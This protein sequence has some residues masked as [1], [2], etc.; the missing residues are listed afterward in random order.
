MNRST[1]IVVVI[2]AAALVAVSAVA[3]HAVL[4]RPDTTDQHH[5]AAQGDGE[6]TT[7]KIVGFGNSAIIGFRVRN[8][9]LLAV[10]E[11]GA[12]RAYPIDSAGHQYRV[13]R[14]SDWTI[15]NGR[16]ARLLFGDSVSDAR[17]AATS[18]LYFTTQHGVRLVAE[19][20]LSAALSKDGLIAYT[21]PEYTVVVVDERLRRLA[22]FEDASQPQW[23]SNGDLLMVHAVEG[24]A[25]DWSSNNELVL[26][27]RDGWRSELLADSSY[28]AQS[29]IGIPGTEAVLFVGRKTGL[30]SFWRLE[31]GSR[32]VT[33]LT[34]VEGTAGE[35][36]V[37]TRQGMWSPDG[38]KYA[39]TIGSKNAGIWIL[40]LRTSVAHAAGP[41]ADP[42]WLTSTRLSPG[43]IGSSGVENDILVE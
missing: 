30:N 19:Q 40:D 1:A 32:D 27:H 20:S 25:A 36:P 33:Q 34:N 9:T 8:G 16:L 4:G 29:P 3:Q 12:V 35:T 5:R 23:L 31:L 28:D 7:T 10:D 14:I 39:F 2:A 24:V 37:P 38:T 41:G 15:E 18:L 17:M 22:E 42:V 43:S 11:A 13:V 6:D 26:V 21:T